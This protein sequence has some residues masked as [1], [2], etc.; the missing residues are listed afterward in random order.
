MTSAHDIP[1]WL[2]VGF[3]VTVLVLLVVDIW[4]YRNHTKSTPKKDLYW[5]IAWVAVSLLF[6]GVIWAEMGSTLAHEY[7]ASYAMEKALSLDNLFVFF[8]IFA[9]LRIPAE[10]QHD[11]LFWGVI[12]AVVFRGLF[13]F[14]GVEALERWEWVTYVFAAILI[15]AAIKA[16]TD[17]PADTEESGMVAWLGRHFRMS[18]KPAEGHFFVTE[19]GKRMA[20]RLL[21][22]LVCIELADVMFAIDSIPAA[23]SITR[24]PFLVYSSNIFAI[25]GLRALYLCVAHHMADLRF[26]HY[27]L[28]AVLAFAG[29]KIIT[30]DWYHI[31]PLVSTI[32]I[33]VLIGSSIAAS[34]RWPAQASKRPPAA[35]K[36]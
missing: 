15:L 20:T 31:P 5:T 8:I 19:N 23:L 21:V 29:I 14:L 17:N 25:L 18:D 3:A 16:F 34:L 7:Y 27:G 28:S 11:V 1:M 33:V 6:G 30:S 10:E 2:W 26:L 12:G 32:V 9:T 22:A 4:S 13:I 24:E 35:I 36:P